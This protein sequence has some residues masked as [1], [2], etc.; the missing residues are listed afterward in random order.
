MFRRS[1]QLPCGHIES[2]VNT[3]QNLQK[4]AQNDLAVYARH[5]NYMVVSENLAKTWQLDIHV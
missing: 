3:T 2:A 1:P 5:A 4:S